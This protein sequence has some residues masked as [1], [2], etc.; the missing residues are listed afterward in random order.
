MRLMVK[1]LKINHHP[2]NDQYVT[3]GSVQITIGSDRPQVQ[4]SPTPEYHIK[5]GGKDFIVFVGDVD[6]STKPPDGENVRMFSQDQPFD[7]ARNLKNPLLIAA[8]KNMSMEITIKDVS[9][10]GGDSEKKP[11]CPFRIIA[12]KIPAHLEPS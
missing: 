3:R 12:V 10:D 6:G 7:I 9:G 4:I 11:L 8:V 1:T 5:H 2:I